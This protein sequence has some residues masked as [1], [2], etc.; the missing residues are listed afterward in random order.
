MSSVEQ[1]QDLLTLVLEGH[2]LM[3]VRAIPFFTAFEIS[4]NELASQLGRIHGAPFQRFQSLQ[5][6]HLVAG[7]QVP[8]TEGEW[9][10]VFVDLEAQVD[11]IALSTTEIT[12]G[13]DRIG[14][15]R[16]RRES[17]ALL[18]PGVFVHLDELLCHLADD[19]DKHPYQWESREQLKSLEQILSYAPVAARGLDELIFE[20]FDSSYRCEKAE[21]ESDVE[22]SCEETVEESPSSSPDLETPKLATVL[23]GVDG[24]D[25]AQW[26]KTLSDPRSWMAKAR[27]RPG[28]RGG[29]S[30]TWDPV[31][32]LNEL[33]K[34]QKATRSEVDRLMR[35]N[36]TLE[37]WLE[38]WKRTQSVFS[39]YGLATKKNP[40]NPGKRGP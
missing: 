15:A 6:F 24:K 18:P 25:A 35:S 36:P 30:A 7:K 28:R 14:R 40:V 39:D 2:K 29:E 20:G 23:D 31:S 16:W 17:V 9:R 3:P 38:A 26:G 5:A 4:P 1:R 11:E 27:R 33:V 8:V 32:L 21:G 10:H 22:S 12:P 37:P 19:F 13:Q 34:R